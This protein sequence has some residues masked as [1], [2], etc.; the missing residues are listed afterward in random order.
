MVLLKMVIQ[1]KNKSIWSDLKKTKNYPKLDNDITT[2]VLII[3][4]GITGLSVAYHL[5][6]SN[7]KVCLVEKNKL[8]KYNYKS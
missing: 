7:L 3:G 6:N 8:T 4:G 2:D 1:L 5:A